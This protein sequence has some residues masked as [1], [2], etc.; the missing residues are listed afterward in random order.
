MN[1]IQIEHWLCFSLSTDRNERR[2]A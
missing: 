2:R 1:Y